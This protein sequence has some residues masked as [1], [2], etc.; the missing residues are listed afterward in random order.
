MASIGLERYILFESPEGISYNISGARILHTTTDLD[1]MVTY[2]GAME[3]R[4]GS[5]YVEQ[6]LRDTID[7]TLSYTIFTSK[8]YVLKLVKVIPNLMTF[9]F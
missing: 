3:L 5:T 6:D 7:E 1:S 8:T 9:G 2:I 4:P